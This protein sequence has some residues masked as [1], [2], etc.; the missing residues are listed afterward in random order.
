PCCE[1]SFT[2][3]RGL[4]LAA[5]SIADRATL[6]LS[7]F[8]WTAFNRGTVLTQKV[9]TGSQGSRLK[10]DPLLSHAG[11]RKRDLGL[12][13]ESGPANRP[14][15]SKRHPQS[16]TVLNRSPK[17]PVQGFPSFPGILEN[18]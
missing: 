9:Q 12:T 7:S 17:A 11:S 14:S 1:T 16:R 15:A 4:H 8:P 2:K 5:V 6:G 13:V 3:P 10:S 18:L